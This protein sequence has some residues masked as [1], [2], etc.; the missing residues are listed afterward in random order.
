MAYTAE[1]VKRLREATAAGMV[2]CKK[3]LDEAGGDFNKA[4]EIIRVKGLKGVTKREGRSTSNGLIAAKAEGTTA[5]ML[6]LNCETDF[7]A[8]GDRFQ[9]VAD[10][11]LGHLFASKQKDLATFVASKLPSGKGVQE[12]IDEANA[13]LGVSRLFPAFLLIQK[14]PMRREPHG[15]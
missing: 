14:S 7:V 12:A 9:A 1:D 2:D 8:K 6:E 13:T 5:V 4:V 15:G 11:L 3:A 10:E